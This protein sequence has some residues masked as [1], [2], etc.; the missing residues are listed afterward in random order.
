MAV[1]SVALLQMET[2]ASPAANPADK[3]L[4]YLSNAG[5]KEME[6]ISISELAIRKAL[7]AEEI[8]LK[9]DKER[10]LYEMR[11][12]CVQQKRRVALRHASYCKSRYSIVAMASGRRTKRAMVSRTRKTWFMLVG[13]V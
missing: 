10:Y 7:S 12:R 6:G 13:P 8:F 2:A 5:H 3:R 4:M 11:E 9:Q 1:L